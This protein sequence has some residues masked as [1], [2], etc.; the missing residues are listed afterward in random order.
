MALSANG[1]TALIGGADPYDFG[2]GAAW[3]FVRSS[4]AWVQQGEPLKGTQENDYSG[5]GFSAALSSNGDTALI[6]GPSPG[7]NEEH[8]A[9]WVFVRNGETWLQQGPS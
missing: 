2:L 9:G 8:G 7:E 5:F 4:E 3:I 6:G 1:D